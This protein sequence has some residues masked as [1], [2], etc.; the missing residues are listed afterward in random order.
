M[1]IGIDIKY[2]RERYAQMSDDELAY[3]VSNNASGLTPEALEI[4]KDE[5]RK[6]GLNPRLENALEIQNKVLT[7]KELNDFCEL[8]RNLDCPVCGT[9]DKLSATMSVVHISTFGFGNVHE[10]NI[11]IACPR[12]LVEFN[13]SALYK[14][15]FL[16]WWDIPSGPIK[17]VMAIR[18][19]YRN[20]R[21]DH[22]I[23]AP[24]EYLK[25]FVMAKLPQLELHRNDPK[26]LRSIISE[27]LEIDTSIFGITVPY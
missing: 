9:R 4:A 14:T 20:K 16:G 11:H 12:C 25:A 24:N 3:L 17:S 19:N 1:S 22:T 13:K 26:Q 2:V 10:K 23:A 27:K 18:F 5:I 15:A 8:I 21:T 6:R 7:V